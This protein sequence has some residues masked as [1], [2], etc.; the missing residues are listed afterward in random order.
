MKLKIKITGLKFPA[1]VVGFLLS[2]KNGKDIYV[3]VHLKANN[4]ELQKDGTYTCKV[5]AEHLDLP[6]DLRKDIIGKSFFGIRNAKVYYT[7]PV[8]EECECKLH[9]FQLEEDKWK[10][11]IAPKT[12]LVDCTRNQEL[13]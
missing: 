6:K 7:I 9:S 11:N 12:C 1:T 4:N 13:E 8:I 5:G 10:L 2:M 3:G